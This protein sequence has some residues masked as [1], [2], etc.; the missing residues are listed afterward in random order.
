MKARVYV[1]FRPEDVFN[2]DQDVKHSFSCSLEFAVNFLQE[3]HKGNIVLHTW[4]I[5]QV[6]IEVTP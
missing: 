6:N 4:K 5:V 3:L 1:T 2:H